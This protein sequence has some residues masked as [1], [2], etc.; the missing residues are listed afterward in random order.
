MEH[1]WNIKDAAAF[2]NVSEMT[3]RRWTNSGRLTCYRLGGRRERRFRKSDLDEFLQGSHYEP[4]KSLG[5]G[6]QLAPDGSHLTHFYSGKEGALAVSIPYLL[7]GFKAGEALLAVMPPERSE[8]LLKQLELQR[9]PVADWLQSGRLTLSTGLDT[10]KA[11]AGYLANFIRKAGEFRVVGDMIWTAR[12][13]WDLN[14][15]R[16]LEEVPAQRSPVK[17]GLLLCQY[18]LEEFSGDY[19]MMAAE[20]HRH[21]IYKGRMEKSLYFAYE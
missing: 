21:I 18:S 16:T 3:I 6:D 13:G 4:M 9:Q 1:L 8:E 12:K 2:L 19:I 10:P 5:V 15:L 20:V 17:N 7:E 14:A 11:M